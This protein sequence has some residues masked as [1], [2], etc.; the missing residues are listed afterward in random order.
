V[1]R[2]FTVGA[3]G[4]LAA[5][6]DVY[7]WSVTYARGGTPAGV[8]DVDRMASLGVQVLWIQ[9]TKADSPDDVLE[10]V[11][12]LALIARAHHHGMRVVPWYLPTLEDTALDLRRLVD[13]AHLPVDGLGVDLESRAVDDPADRSARAVAVSAALRAALP[14]RAL[15]AIPLPPV[16]LEGINPRYWPGYPWA[17]LAPNYDV[18]L[19][20]SYWTLR[21]P[22]SGYRDAFV[23][24]AA[25]IDR[26]RTDLGQPAAPC[27]ALGGIADTTSAADIAGMIGAAGQR[28]CIGGGLYDYRT[29]AEGLWPLLQSLRR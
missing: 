9:A 24:T 27:V 26:M 11:R 23:Y 6:L 29:T 28:G 13:I 12:L 15:A 25:N 16:Q 1:P 10:P 22:A 21:T 19:P 3:Y 17:G 18:W 7:D 5:W 14:G 8:P 20:M 4:G 2:P